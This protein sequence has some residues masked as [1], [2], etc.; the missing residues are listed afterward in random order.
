MHCRNDFELSNKDPD[1][2]PEEYP[3]TILYTKSAACM[4]K[5][6]KNTKHTRHIE[7]RVNFVRNG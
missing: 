2:V 5:N 7:S 3:L 1:I 6:V 4:D